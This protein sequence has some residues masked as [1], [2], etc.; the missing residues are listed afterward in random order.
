MI[1]IVQKPADNLIAKLAMH[2]ILLVINVN[3]ELFNGRFNQLSLRS[4][5]DGDDDENIKRRLM[6]QLKQN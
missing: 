5:R 2:K 4:S 3:G 1:P 6:K